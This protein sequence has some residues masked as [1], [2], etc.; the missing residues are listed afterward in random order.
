MLHVGT[1]RLNNAIREIARSEGI[2]VRNSDI[3]EVNNLLQASAETRRVQN[4]AWYRVAPYQEG[5]EIDLGDERHTRVRITSGKV[6]VVRTGST[7]LFYRTPASLP[8][9]IPAETGNLD[10]LK[11]YLP[12][13]PVS[14]VLLIA[15]VTY[16]LA[17]P[18]TPSSKFV[19]LVFQGPQGSGKSALCNGVLLNLLDPNL[20]GVQVIPGH[21]K[22]LAI[23]AQGAHVL[24]FDNV[25]ELKHWV[26][27]HLCVAATG[28][29]LVARKLYSDADQSVLHL[30]VAIV[31]NG[32]PSLITQ[33][34]LAQRALQ[35]V[36]RPMSEVTRKSETE[37]SREFADDLPAILRGLYDLTADI[38][39][40]LPTA[41]V[42]NPERMLDFV[43]WLAAMEEA[44]GVP[45]GV[46][47]SAYSDVL[48]TGQ[49][50]SL[51]ENLLA[52]SVVEF[53]DDEVP[54][55]WSGTP[56]ELLAKLTTRAT[57]GTQRSRE[58]PLNPIALSKRLVPLQAGLLSQ[59]IRID[60]Q[61]GK[62]R[63]IVITKVRGTND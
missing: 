50:D 11:K 3:R 6:E 21:P 24:F 51:L 9:A 55:R 26:A 18:K 17:R 43:R 37:L 46:Y 38:F 8:L 27:D 14:K 40:H 7:T 52:A 28:G 56:A 33:S 34:D 15:W 4:N 53:V 39:L 22:D 36:L 10:L 35:I 49:L 59:G 54:D 1:K 2:T 47:Q 42:T 16:T 12:V 60:L 5:V 41:E 48:Q 31:L 63:E 45:V 58:W 13:D 25:R 62:E 20:I 32:I 19:I 30:H 61:R 57:R 44:Q 29:S 23:A